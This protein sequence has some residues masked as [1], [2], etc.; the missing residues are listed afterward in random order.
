[1]EKWAEWRMVQVATLIC[2]LLI[3]SSNFRTFK[4]QIII[5]P[6]NTYLSSLLRI[7]VFV[8]LAVYTGSCALNSVGR[9]EYKSSFVAFVGI[10]YCCDNWRR[11]WLST[12]SSSCRWVET[13]SVNF[14]DQR[15]YWLS[16]MWYMSMENY[17][18]LMILTEENSWVVHQS[19]QEILPVE[20]SGSKQEE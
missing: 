2:L 9:Y 15:A 5:P 3:L 20:S 18:G 7:H 8:D 12:S 11:W 1:M 17:G 14:G 13:T 16:F 6:A 4:L 10:N 19:S